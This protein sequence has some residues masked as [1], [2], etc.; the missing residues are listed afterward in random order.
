MESKPDWAGKNAFGN[1][2]TLTETASSFSVAAAN[3]NVYILNN[4]TTKDVLRI[5]LHAE[6]NSSTTMNGHFFFVTV[7]TADPSEMVLGKVKAKFDAAFHDVELWLERAREGELLN[8]LHFSRN[9]E[10]GTFEHVIDAA[11]NAG[12]CP[13]PNYAMG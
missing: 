4:A 1:V 10:I 6:T 13:F 3:D 2:P 7:P 5:E 8:A 9:L 11:Q 12:Y